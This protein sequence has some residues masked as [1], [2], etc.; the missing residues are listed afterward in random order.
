MTSVDGM[1]QGKGCNKQLFASYGFNPEF[2]KKC[3]LPFLPF[4]CFLLFFFFP[5][6]GRVLGG[7]PPLLVVVQVLIQQLRPSLV[8]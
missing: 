6:K 7:V 8:T 3:F 1:G 2:S 5:S 4:F